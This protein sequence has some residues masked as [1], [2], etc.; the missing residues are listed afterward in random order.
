MF[1]SPR[2]ALAILHDTRAVALIEFGLSLPIVLTIG[3][4]GIETGNFALTNMK[5][6]QITMNLADNISRVG[7]ASKL[8]L[9][10]LRE[11]DI[12]EAFQAARLQGGSYGLTGNGRLV[13]SSLEQNSGKNQ[14]IHWQRCLGLKSYN[15]SYGT[16]GAVVTTGMGPAAGPRI[17]APANSAVMFVE[18]TYDYRPLFLN[19]ILSGQ[20]LHYTAAFLVRDKR[21][22]S[23]TG[24][25]ADATAATCDKYSA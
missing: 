2:R 11:S 10:K 15:S 18:L 7:E 4:L 24:I 21:D 8:A 22:L 19:T 1:V 12:N 17:K 5:M 16:Q 23:G 3:V 13:L 20:Q 6:S 25:S 9:T 14:Y